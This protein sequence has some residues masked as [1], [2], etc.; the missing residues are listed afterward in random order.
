[1]ESLGVCAG[2][3]GVRRWA[4]RMDLVVDLVNSNIEP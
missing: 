2:W 1:M 3:F 4:A